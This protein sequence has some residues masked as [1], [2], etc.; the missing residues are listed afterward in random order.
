MMLMSRLSEDED[1]RD[2]KGRSQKEGRKEGVR[3][4]GRREAEGRRREMGQEFL[5]RNERCFRVQEEE[6]EEEERE[7]GKR[8]RKRERKAVD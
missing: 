8:K 3:K 1:A 6:E 5:Q 7:V 4:E 2:L